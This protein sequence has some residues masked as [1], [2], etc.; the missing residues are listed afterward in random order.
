M[1][2]PQEK[3]APHV[4]P[5]RSDPFFIVLNVGSGKGDCDVAEATIRGVLEEAGQAHEFLAVD[6]AEALPAAARR[7]V[8]QAKQQKG[9]VVA[10]G[11]DGTISAVAQAALG[12]TRPFGVLPQGTFNYFGRTHGIPEDTAESTRELLDASV[13]PVQVGMVNERIFLVNA[14]LGLYPELLEERETRKQRFGRTRLVALWSALLTLLSDHR[15]LIIELEHEL[16]AQTLRT[17]MLFVGNNALQLEQLGIAEASVV[18]EG[19]LTA[20]TV[21]PVGTAAMFALLV[22]GALGRLGEARSVQSFAFRRMTVH[23][24][25]PYGLR[26][27]KV[28]MDGEIFWLRIPIEFRVAP[29]PLLLLAPARDRSTSQ[30]A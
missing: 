3:V 16:G 29:H 30:A 22:R 8:E 15:S 5:A 20:I 4:K 18:Q 2:S 14:S 6:N 23:P 21:E 12:S 26:R 13:R 28:A 10:A 1:S 9:V 27:M 19:L 24:R 25:R 11:G 17:P 7:A